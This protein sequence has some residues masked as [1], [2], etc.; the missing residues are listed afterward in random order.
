VLTSGCVVGPDYHPPSATALNVPAAFNAASPGS[1]QADADLGRWWQG[2][3]DPVLTQLVDRALRANL[4][5]DVAGS[6]L[7]QSRASLRAARSAELPSLDFGGSVS[8]SIGRDGG[9]ETSFQAGFDAA[10]EVDLFG[11]TRRSVEAARADAQ[12]ALASLH[13]SQLSIAGEVAVNYVSARLAQARLGIA[14]ENLAA[15]GETLQIVGWRVQAGLVSSLDLEQARQLRAQTAASIPAIESDYVAALNRLAVLSGEPPGAVTMLIEATGGIPAAPS[16]YSTPIPLEVIRR[17][18]D[19]D[20]AE[21]GLAAETARV[22][23]QTAQ[24]YPALR[25]GGSFGGSGTS[26][27]QLLDTS[28]GS[29]AATLAAPILDG[30]RIRAGIE[31]Q[32]AVAAIALSNYR[33]TV[34]IAL[35][36]VEN[37][38]TAVS[39]ADRRA[40]EIGI[41]E[42]AARNSAVYARS[43]YRTGLIDYRTLLE[44][45]RSLLSTEDASATAAADRAT[46]AIRLYKA[47]GGGWQYAPEPSS[48]ASSTFTARPR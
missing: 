11:G 23:V 2:F 15:Q 6:R 46:A 22:G 32:R 39:A 1:P 5:V 37:A 35:E 42:G 34:L 3:A 20:V 48:V 7:R 16:A 31:G 26:V 41:A 25:L 10:Y 4:D 40:G 21:R 9:D 27:S 38:L 24:L 8:R 47:L 29:L 28:I 18:P 44:A 12:G 17:R 45:E 43:Q 36:E 13:A 19:V 33:Q 14:R 30:G